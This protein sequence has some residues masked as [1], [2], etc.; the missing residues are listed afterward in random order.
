M[1]KAKLMKFIQQIIE[2]GSMLKA[3]LALSELKNIM[4]QQNAE[5]ELIQIVSM[6]IDSVPEAK[7]SLEKGYLTEEDLEIAHE[8]AK[9]RIA[10]EEA[11]R[12]HGRC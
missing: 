10:R 3:G 2:T 6:A 4:E 9:A 8:R 1:S 7:K 5:E 11:A 12:A